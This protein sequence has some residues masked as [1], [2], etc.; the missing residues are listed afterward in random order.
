M[1]ATVAHMIDF[2]SDEGRSYMGTGASVFLTDGIILVGE[3]LPCIQVCEFGDS[4]S[5][6]T[7]VKM[8]VKLITVIRPGSMR[9]L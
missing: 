9:V 2:Y 4:L 3:R 1:L 5:C 6:L 7:A 8:H